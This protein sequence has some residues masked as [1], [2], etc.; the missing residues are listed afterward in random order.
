M[1]D[2]P[3]A[4]QNILYLLEQHDPDLHWS[5]LNTQ[6]QIALGLITESDS[7]AFPK[8]IYFAKNYHQYLLSLCNAQDAE[9]FYLNFIAAIKDLLKQSDYYSVLLNA[10]D[11]YFHANLY[12]NALLYYTLFLNYVDDEPEYQ[13][14]KYTVID[15]ISI[16]EKE[17]CQKL[18]EIY[19]QSHP[20]ATVKNQN[21]NFFA[22]DFNNVQRERLKNMRNLFSIPQMNNLQKNITF[23]APLLWRQEMTQFLQDS[24]NRIME[25]L[26]VPPCQF[27][28]IFAGSYGRNDASP[29]SDVEPLILIEP[30]LTTELQDQMRLHPYFT[31]LISF[32]NFHL[33]LLGDRWT[34]CKDKQNQA[35]R[36]FTGL[37]LDDFDLQYLTNEDILRR[38]LI[39][40]PNAMAD[41]I[42]DG[43]YEDVDEFYFMSYGLQWTYC[44]Y[45]TSD[46]I[47][48]YDDFLKA[49]NAKNLIR[50]SDYNLNDSIV[51][52]HNKFQTNWFERD[53]V[54]FKLRFLCRFTYH[55][56]NIYLARSNA[57]FK[58]IDQSTVQ[59]IL[60]IW[61]QQK[62]LN[63][64]FIDLLETAFNYLHILK[65]HMHITNKGQVDLYLLPHYTP[66]KNQYDDSGKCLYDA[67]RLNRQQVFCLK[68]IDTL[69][70]IMHYCLP[71]LLTCLDN[72]DFDPVAYIIQYELP[73][74]SELWLP[75]IVSLT[76]NFFNLPDKYLYYYEMMSAPHR[77]EYFNELQK[78]FENQH[79]GEQTLNILRQYDNDIELQT[80]K[81]KEMMIVHHKILRIVQNLLMIGYS[82]Y[83]LYKFKLLDI[84]LY[85]TAAP[86]SSQLDISAFAD[87]MS[88]E[89]LVSF[90]KRRR[91]R[92]NELNLSGCQKISAN[93]VSQ[94]FSYC[95]FLS[96]LNINQ[97]SGNNL[98]LN[99]PCNTLLFVSA[100]SCEHLASI[101]IDSKNLTVLYAQH[102]PKLTDINLATISLKELYLSGNINLLEKVLIHC[103]PHFVKLTQLSLRGCKQIHNIKFREKYPYMLGLSFNKIK[104][105]YRHNFKIDYIMNR[106]RFGN[107][108]H[109][110]KK[111]LLELLH[112]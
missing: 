4:L 112:R 88:D 109:K 75:E 63:N 68:G 29:Y 70:K 22:N 46:S 96:V 72:A 47:S 9:Y 98:T 18:L 51:K 105:A 21:E 20:Q 55:I 102:N 90:L 45:Q 77:A 38:H 49:F 6:F 100:N 5:Q 15:R 8:L 52:C 14:V 33:L 23:N 35:F 95:P 101:N 1:V 65:S 86:L 82:N 97:W 78:H 61:R 79:N 50:Y 66:G 64:C 26:G 57:L 41:W 103:A 56:L 32:L 111:A 74:N 3:G 44:L 84:Y 60:I 91:H 89:I 36:Y 93:A 40:T 13:L 87:V 67:P 53:F 92:L 99:N 11:N 62:F 81:Y 39:N 34:V 110:G 73:L 80:E 31:A 85:F 10:G 71:A 54:N 30:Q 12:E 19:I 108:Y 7:N 58:L 25:N 42:A 43:F 76:T 27:A 107:I 37:H 69:I 94:I 104:G 28:L 59:T 83:E 17:V 24:L 48:L 16:I 2:K 106:R